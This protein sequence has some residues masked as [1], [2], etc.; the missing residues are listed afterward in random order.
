MSISRKSLGRSVAGISTTPAENQA[1]VYLPGM[2][3]K[4][5][6]AVTSA[7]DAFEDIGSLMKQAFSV[8]NAKPDMTQQEWAAVQN[9]A[10]AMGLYDAIHQ[11]VCARITGL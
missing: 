4:W 1:H 7:T 11:E 10:M 5:V 6:P 2:N 8:L 9:L 3:I